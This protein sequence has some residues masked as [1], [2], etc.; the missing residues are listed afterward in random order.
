MS[1]SFARQDR[2]V[3]RE[4]IVSFWCP[5][6]GSPLTLHQPDSELKDRLLATC[7]DCKSWYVTDTQDSDLIPVSWLAKDISID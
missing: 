7:G 3:S 1:A 2:E 4:C 6:C 5:S